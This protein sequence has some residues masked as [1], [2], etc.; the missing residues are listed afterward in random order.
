MRCHCWWGLPC[1]AWHSGM[2]TAD[3]LAPC[4]PRQIADQL[5]HLADLQVI[6]AVT[7]VLCSW[8]GV[9]SLHEVCG[10]IW[11][12]TE[13]SRLICTPPD[14][15]PPAYHSLPIQSCGGTLQYHAVCSAPCAS[16]AGGQRDTQLQ[17]CALAAPSS[18]Q[19]TLAGPMFCLET[20]TQHFSSSSNAELLAAGAG[21]SHFWADLRVSA[22]VPHRVP[23]PAAQVWASS[24]H[25]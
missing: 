19:S 6:H 12:E 10:H 20:L 14:T 2:A 7:R 16:T 9:W 22:A 13:N 23:H 15:F 5:Y 25:C 1:Y 24:S 11:R 17:A 8:D 21:S 4:S 18:L 3:V